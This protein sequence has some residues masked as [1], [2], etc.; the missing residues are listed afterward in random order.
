MEGILIKMRI[1]P[2]KVDHIDRDRVKTTALVTVHANPHNAVAAVKWIQ[3]MNPTEEPSK[4]GT[5]LYTG[6]NM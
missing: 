2:Q 6:Q 1:S 4:L 5:S 3:I